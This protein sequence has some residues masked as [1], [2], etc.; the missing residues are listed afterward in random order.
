MDSTSKADYNYPWWEYA[1]IGAH[2]L[3]MYGLNPKKALMYTATDASL[4][5]IHFA[6]KKYPL[7]SS[8]ALD[9]YANDQFFSVYEIYKLARN[10]AE[11]G[12][13]QDGWKTYNRKDLMLAP[14]RRE[15]LFQPIVGITLAVTTTVAVVSTLLSDDAIWK[16]GEAYINNE[17]VPMG[18]AVPAIVASNFIRYNA[19]AIGEEALFRGVLYEEF[20]TVFGPVKGKILDMI[21]FPAIHIPK[22]IVLN[23]SAFDISKQF[24]IRSATTLLFDFAYDKGGLPASVAMHFWFNAISFTTNWLAKSG[25]P[26]LS[27]S[28]STKF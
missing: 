4:L 5:G 23:K 21:I 16:T 14:F 9:M 1:A 25:T 8:V 24:V 26:T 17:Q 2:H 12:L 28:F 7:V 3:P 10:R 11:P 15:N 20:K 13:Y 22:D 27:L 6:T 19:T 18:R